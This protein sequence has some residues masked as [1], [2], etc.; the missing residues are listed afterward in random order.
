M[1]YLDFSAFSLHGEL[2]AAG[3]N[4]GCPASAMGAASCIRAVREL[5]DVAERE[6]RCPAQQPT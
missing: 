4:F 3:E 5:I 6:V 1:N 2:W